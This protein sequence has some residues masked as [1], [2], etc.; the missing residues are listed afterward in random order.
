MWFL[1]VTSFN[2]TQL[3]ELSR[4]QTF[5]GFFSKRNFSERRETKV[6]LRDVNVTFSVHIEHLPLINLAW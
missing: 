4:L 1:H 5:S 6:S 3:T 2:L